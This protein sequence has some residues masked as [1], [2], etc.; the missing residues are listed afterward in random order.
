VLYSCG[1]YFIDLPSAPTTAGAPAGSDADDADG[2]DGPLAQLI[3]PPEQ[4]LFTATPQVFN[5]YMGF[6][7]DAL[8][9]LKFHKQREAKPKAY[10]NRFGPEHNAV[11]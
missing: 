7:S 3:L 10:K 5:N 4:I 11:R 1:S 2:S 8:I 9:T 6:G